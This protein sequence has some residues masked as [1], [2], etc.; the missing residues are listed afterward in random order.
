MARLTVRER[1]VLEVLFKGSTYKETSN[2]LNCSIS[3]IKAHT[4]SIYRKFGVCSIAGAI[5]EGLC[6]GELKA[7]G[8]FSEEEVKQ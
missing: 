3:N 4:G 8:A 5:Y 2:A 6:S 1:Q 7:P